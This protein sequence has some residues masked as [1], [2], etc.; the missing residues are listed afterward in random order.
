MSSTTEQLRQQSKRQRRVAA[1][2]FYNG[3]NQLASA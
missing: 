3:D 1:K 2:L